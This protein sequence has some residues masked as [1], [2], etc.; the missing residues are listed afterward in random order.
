MPLYE[1]SCVNCKK[2][3]EKLVLAKVKEST[4]P[5]QILQRCAGKC[6]AVTRHV[7]LISAPAYVGMTPPGTSKKATLMRELRKPKDENWKK[8]VKLGLAPDGKPLTNLKSVNREEWEEQI[9]T[10]I[11][12]LKEKQMEIAGRAEKGELTSVLEGAT[13]E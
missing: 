12:D 6:S 8:R 1:Y 13:R 4:V 2:K 9:Q 11:P 3:V 10:A 5:Q 7:R